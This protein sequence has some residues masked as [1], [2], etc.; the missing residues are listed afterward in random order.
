[1]SCINALCLMS[2]GAAM[3]TRLWIHA[4]PGSTFQA[5]A[6]L[7]SLM[8][9]LWCAP[10]VCKQGQRAT[11][12]IPITSVK[13]VMLARLLMTSAPRPWMQSCLVVL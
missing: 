12:S 3:F 11:F 1:M 13:R 2:R 6:L 7:Q 8:Q 10:R 9:S 4:C 5:A